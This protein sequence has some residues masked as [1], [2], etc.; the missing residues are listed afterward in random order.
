MSIIT[1][2]I[3]SEVAIKLTAKKQEEINLLRTELREEFESIYLKTIPSEVLKC[4][5]KFPNYF[6]AR[7]E[8]SV[9]GNGFNYQ[10]L[11]FTKK[12]PT[13]SSH[14]LPNSVDCES[15]LKKENAIQ[16]KS[17]EISKLRTDIEVALFS[18]RSYKRIIEQFPEAEPFLPE[19]ISNALAINISDIQSKLK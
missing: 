6:E 3:A 10:R 5:E 2:V 14:Y 16:D 7:N 1:K 15:L 13:S 18:L 11:F 4:Y 17:K 19:K 8:V 12:L 9:S